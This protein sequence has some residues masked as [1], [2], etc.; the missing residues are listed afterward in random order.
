MRMFLGSSGVLKL[1]L[2]SLATDTE[3]V[4]K[5]LVEYSNDLLSLGV[6]GLRLDAS[7]RTFFLDNRSVSTCFTHISVQIWPR[8]M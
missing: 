3:Y 2:N 5:R 1:D 6:A 7:K 8:R 4:R